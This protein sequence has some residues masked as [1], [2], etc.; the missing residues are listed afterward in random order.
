MVAGARRSRSMK[1]VA[2]RKPSSKSVIEYRRG[3]AQK[4]TCPSG[5]ELPGTARGG[6]HELGGLT[7]TQRRP[8]R[9]FGGVLSS[10]ALRVVMRERAKELFSAPESAGAIFAPGAVCLKIAGRDAGKMCVVTETIDANFVKVDG[11]T[12][13]RKVN[14]KHLEPTGKRV[15]LSKAKDA[16][17][18]QAALSE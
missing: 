16:K 5:R 18:L 14:T 15:D 13:P 10:P 9:P 6:K 8:S 1:R 11:F 2:V 17:A 4:P 12:R 3:R 7:K